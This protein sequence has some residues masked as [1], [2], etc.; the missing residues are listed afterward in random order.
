MVVD[1]ST[2]A[3]VRGVF[4]VV[5]LIST[6]YSSPSRFGGK[7]GINF[8]G[9]TPYARPKASFTLS[10]IFFFVREC[11]VLT[12][13]AVWFFPPLFIFYI[14]IAMSAY[15]RGRGRMSNVILLWQSNIIRSHQMS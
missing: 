10:S 5:S 14:D 4:R 11:A 9:G 1:V 2:V 12:W 15:G 8:L 6:L 3:A 7:S 13:T